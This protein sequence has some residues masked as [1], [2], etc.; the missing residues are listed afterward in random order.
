MRERLNLARRLVPF[1][2]STCVRCIGNVE[3]MDALAALLD[4]PRARGA[5][6]LR[7][8]WKPPWS[9]RIEAESP[10][11]LLLVARGH[12][13]ISP[14]DAPPVRLEAGDVAITRAPDHYTVS[15]DPHTPYDIVIDR[16]Q[17]CRTVGGEP[18]DEVMS[19]GVRSW[20]SHADGETVMMVGAYGSIGEVGDRLV[21]ALPPV[22]WM[23]QDEWDSP[24]LPL[25][26][27]EVLR[28]EPGQTAVLDRMLDL[29]VISFLRTWF[30]RPDAEPPVWYAAQGDPVV[31]RAL[32]LIQNNPAEP[33]T[34]A[35]I[36]SET[37]VSRAVLARRF[38]ELVG[39]PPMSF[40]TG[41]RLDLAADLLRRDDMTIGAIAQRVGYSSPYALSTAF[42]RERGIS[43]SQHRDLAAATI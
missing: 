4:G 35:T 29:V 1:G 30:A 9:L 27:D 31:G 21:R 43:P 42:K 39:E 20:G 36:A 17:Q 25:L 34:I 41:W 40:L 12:L 24:L 22:V 38:N 33:W 2:Y 19:L 32:R 16:G 3:Q 26:C 23:R 10:A 18:L 28:D 7:T 37:G 11:T 6:M 8:A 15:D 5:F 13:W 14:D